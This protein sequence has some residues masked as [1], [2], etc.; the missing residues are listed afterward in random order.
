MS[1]RRDILP[2]PR[3][4]G[5]SGRPGRPSKRFFRVKVATGVVR[6]EAVA[7]VARVSWAVVAAGAAAKV[8]VAAARVEVTTV[9]E[10]AAPVVPLLAATA[11]VA[12]FMGRCWRCNRRGH[13]REEYTTKEKDVLAKCARCSCFGH[14]RSTCSSDAAVLVIELPM[15]EEDLAVEI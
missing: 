4:R 7:A 14:E 11:T 13:I 6:D 2:C 1:R 5:R 8:E 3:R 12:D 9:E 10:A 15:S